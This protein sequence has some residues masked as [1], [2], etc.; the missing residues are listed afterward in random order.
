MQQELKF[1]VDSALLRE[2]GEKL[3]ETVHLALS[4]LVKNSYDAD[5]TEVEVI[6]ETTDEGKTRIKVI[7][8]GVGMNFEAVERYWMRIATT[9]K[10]KQ[11][12]STVFG[13]HLTGA[14]G[15][16]RFSCRRLGTHL[17]LITK[18]TADGNLVGK[19]SNIQFTRVEF[20]WTKFEAGTDVTTIKCPGEQNTIHENEVTGTTLIIESA[21]EEWSHRGFSWLKRQLAVLAA[22]QGAKRKGFKDDPGFLIM[23]SAPDFEGGIRDLRE[24][25]INSGWGTLDAHI[26][27][28]GRA[29]YEL[30]ALGLG[31]RTITS[32]NTYPD[33]KG[34][35]LKLGVL[36]YSHDQIRDKTVLSQK[37]IGDII[38]EWGGV[39]IKFR[40]FRVGSYGD[41]DWLSIDYDRGLRKGTPKS[42][43]LAF[44]ESLRGVD[45]SR[46]LLNMLSAKSYVG[47]VEISNE[48]SGFE[49]K[50]NREGFLASP[51]MDQ[52]KQ[53]V[54]F[55]IDWSTI[56]RDYYLRQ[57]FQKIAINAKEEFEYVIDEKIESNRVVETALEY[58]DKEIRTVART[59]PS[60]ERREVEQSLTKATE[61]I[62]RHNES[63][64]SELSHLRLIAST[65][66]LLLIFS[67]EV[68]SLLA[69]LEHSKNSLK[70]IAKSLSGN[71]KNDVLEVADSF[72]ELNIR[73]EELLQMTSLVGT[74]KSRAKPG[75]I[76]LKPKLQKIEK[77]FALITNKYGVQIDYSSVPD[78]ILVKRFLE[79]EIYSILLNV[80]S[81][82]IK[83]VIAGGKRKEIQITTKSENDKVILTVRDSGIGLSSDRFREVFTPFVS[84]PEG[85]LYA[86][87]EDQLNPEDNMIVG[88]G[89]GIGL[90]IVKEIIKAHEG[91]ISF[92]EPSEG[93]STEL[94][95]V[96]E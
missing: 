80:L 15:I 43:L 41:D 50:A 94:E 39:Q 1:T 20:P 67:H 14:K 13:R 61:A 5:A 42:E 7:D 46:S 66:T 52:L 90:G 91:K 9:N 56:L 58:I 57:E 84:D 95:I 85:K 54:R 75:R 3:V 60:V 21:T 77:V 23:L 30:H 27:E 47:S 64:I 8:N 92:K 44:A 16:G 81:N 86:N 88:T 34:V 93:W 78:N 36:V 96:L 33:L 82:S 55:G 37:T 89:S 11:N 76:A 4:E 45:A 17:T 29:I 22:N 68:K 40:G 32:S 83:A 19:Q 48:S 35:K 25:L 10:D 24:D 71:N 73:L 53:F 12:L 38:N 63:N 74:D 72:Q 65:S 26:N 87:L 2:L 6:F 18:G 51:S 70:G 79:A 28:R 69:L 31:R 59:L 49:M 62:R